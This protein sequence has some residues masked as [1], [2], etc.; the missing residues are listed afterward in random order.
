MTGC[1]LFQASARADAASSRR[2]WNIILHSGDDR[3]LSPSY[4]QTKRRYSRD[5]DRD[6]TVSD[7]RFGHQL[8]DFH[9]A[10]PD[11]QNV[12]LTPQHGQAVALQALHEHVDIFSD[13]VGYFYGLFDTCTQIGRL[14]YGLEGVVGRRGLL[15]H[16]VFRSAPRDND[17]VAS[18][19]Q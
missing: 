11:D 18:H 3:K 1:C 15:A 12:T 7:N 8:V 16:T 5:P 9:I 10:R 17:P 14:S 2:C 13:S 4:A 6:D 19:Q